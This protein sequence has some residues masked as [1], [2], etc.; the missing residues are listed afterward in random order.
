M[1]LGAGEGDDRRAPP[2]SETRGKAV[3]RAS[4]ANW[5]TKR[6]AARL[7][8]R[9]GSRGAL[10]GLS[11]LACCLAGSGRSK[12]EQGGKRKP[13]SYFQRSSQEL[14]SN[15]NLNSKKYKQCNSMSATVNSYSSLI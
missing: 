6:K 12:K 4:W 8:R 3:E 10:A 14:N 15:T 5:A 9:A 11:E 2:G 7:I 13:F 1:R